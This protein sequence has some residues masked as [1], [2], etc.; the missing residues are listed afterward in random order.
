MTGRAQLITLLFLLALPTALSATT[1]R[2]EPDG[3]GDVPTIQAAVDT[4]AP[5]DT[6]VLGS[7]VFTGDGNINITVPS[8]NFLMMSET[9]TPEDCI[10]DCEG[11]LGPER[12]AFFFSLAYYGPTVRGLTIRNGTGRGSDGVVY[13]EGSPKF[14]NCTFENN[15]GYLAGGAVTCGYRVLES[16]PEFKHCTFR[17][18]E[19]GTWGGAIFIDGVAL[20]VDIDSCEFY[21][22]VAAYGGAVYCMQH[23]AQAEITNS[24]FYGNVAL[25]EGGAIF[26]GNMTAY[27]IGCT[28]FTNSAPEGSAIATIGSMWGNS[29]ANVSDCIIAYNLGGC[30][31]YQWE[32]LPGEEDISCTD[33]FGNEGG[34]WVDG[35]AACLGVDGN[36]SAA[37]EFCNPDMEPYD[38]SLC[39]C[40][41][42][43]P[44]NHPDGD[45]CGLIGALGEGCVCDPT[46]TRPST[47]GAIKTLYR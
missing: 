31:Y 37:P 8:K 17:G 35:L 2:V 28:F 36:F 42:C 21:E 30:G 11:H 14:R 5:G 34:D 32:V 18:N 41:P 12:W 27:I 9:G 10:I 29:N 26:V 13:S 22:N 25:A 46:S 44:G 19:S 6:L 3:S 16:H 33:I 43:L 45:D 20:E 1:W 39:D 4:L 40:S 15:Y 23:E 24:L 7:G 47:W 38:L